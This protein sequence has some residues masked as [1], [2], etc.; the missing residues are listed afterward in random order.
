MK[1]VVIV[2]VSDPASGRLVSMACEP[3]L[4]EEAFDRLSWKFAETLVNEEMR[5]EIFTAY[6]DDKGISFGD[7]KA[8]IEK[9]REAFDY[10]FSE[11]EDYIEKNDN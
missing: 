1:K 4:K 8:L 10:A 11:E 6:P 5:E 3:E 9:R 7:M 2:A